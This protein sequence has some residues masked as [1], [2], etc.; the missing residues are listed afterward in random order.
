MIK[1][2][3][4]GLGSVNEAVQN[5]ETYS[6]LG[7]KA[8]EIAFTY[9][10]YIKTEKEALIIRKAAEKFG[11]ELTIHAH[12]WIN[13]SSEEKEK[14]EASK[15]RILECCKVGTW[16]GATRVIFHPG[17]Y[18]KKD[19]QETYL[20]IKNEILEL[21]QEIKRRGYTPKLAPETTGKLNVF[22]SIDEIYN[23]TQDTKCS[24]C[25]DFAHILAREKDYRFDYVL[26]K[27][28]EFDS[29]HIHFSGIEYGEK[30]ERNH[31]KTEESEIKKIVTALV[32]KA[33]AK[34]IVVINESPFPVEDSVLA[35]QV[36]KGIEVSAK[37]S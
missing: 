6:K 32:E 27:F 4:A 34:N 31:K 25:I 9:G 18:G 17:Y 3:P 26:N 21:Q 30:G 13:L 28:K 2:G 24:F 33:K 14:V 23:L 15:K 35:T 19:K 8:C 11:I 29:M 5:L 36:F 37:K 10:P 7:L 22:G 12:Y 16:L 1:F 20:Q